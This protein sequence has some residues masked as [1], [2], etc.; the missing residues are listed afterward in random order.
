MQE[1]EVTLAGARRAFADGEAAFAESGVRALG[2]GA[3]LGMVTEGSGRRPWQEQQ[4]E[5]RAGARG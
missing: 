2:E 1:N 4:A 5:R 3:S